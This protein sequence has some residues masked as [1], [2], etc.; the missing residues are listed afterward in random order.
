MW[1]DAA[2]AFLLVNRDMS[3]DISTANL[4]TVQ[5][6]RL[7]SQKSL[8]SG[9][10]VVQCMMSYAQAAKASQLEGFTSNQSSAVGGEISP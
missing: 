10:C 1:L 4:E 6:L 5:F 7:T 3:S 2:S 8:S 9:R